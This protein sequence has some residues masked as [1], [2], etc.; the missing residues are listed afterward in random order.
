MQSQSSFNIEEG[1][2]KGGESD[3]IDVEG[4]DAPLLALTMKKGGHE[5]RKAGSL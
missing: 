2:R 5:P 1:G 4:L 3:A